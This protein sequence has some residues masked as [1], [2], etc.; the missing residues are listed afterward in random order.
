MTAGPVPVIG[1]GLAPLVNLG[2]AQA[3]TAVQRSVCPH[4]HL[5]SC[6]T[7]FSVTNQQRGGRGIW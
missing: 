5:D 6:K 7:I 1:T 4:W 3:L 2:P